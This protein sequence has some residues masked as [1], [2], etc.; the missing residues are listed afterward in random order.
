[1]HCGCANPGMWRSWLLAYGVRGLRLLVKFR[2]GTGILGNRGVELA[3]G[4]AARR[5]IG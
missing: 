4:G 5:L 1:M 3:L 2:N